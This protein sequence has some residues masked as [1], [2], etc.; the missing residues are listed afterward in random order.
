[1]KK[2]I[3]I[4]LF[5][6]SFSFA[7]GETIANNE[8]Y[9]IEFAARFSVLSGDAYHATIS[10]DLNAEW[11]E[12][13]DFYL[14]D[15]GGFRIAIRKDKKVMSVISYEKCDGID[16]LKVVCCSTFGFTNEV[17]SKEFMGNV[18]DLYMRAASGENV[19]PF[20]SD[21]YMYVVSPEGEDFPNGIR[22]I[23]AVASEIVK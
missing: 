9:F 22:F 19:I 15:K 21:N 11:E 16:F 2:I 12:Y 18:L 10:L 20:T 6:F 17:P 3:S 5:L 14:I 7:S 4:V 13:G 23:A 1:M 8:D